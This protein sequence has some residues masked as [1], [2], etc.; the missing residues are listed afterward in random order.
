M[1][2]SRTLLAVDDNSLDR[3]IMSQTLSAAFPDARIRVVGEPSE[4]ETLCG[5]QRFDCVLL[6]QNLPQMDGLTLARRLRTSDPHMPIILV[7]SIGDEML[8]AEAMRGGVS[9]YLTK[10]R[11]TTEAARRVVDRAIQSAAQQRLIDQ[12]HE[13]LETFA[14]ALAHD[15]KQPIRQIMTFSQMITDD[16]SSV[17]KAGVQKHLD[18]LIHAAERLDKLVDVM[19][20]YTLLSQPPELSNVRLDAVVAAIRASLTPLLSELHAELEVKDERAVIRGNETLMIQVLQNLIVN[21][22]RYN[23]SRVPRVEVLVRREAETYVIEVR[24]NGVGIAAE[25]L[26]EIFKPLIRLHSHKE[27]PGSGLG[28]TL[29]RKAVM[30]QKGDIWCE[31]TPGRGS[32][33]SLRLAAGG[34]TAKRRRA[35]TPA[36]PE[37]ARRLS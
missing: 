16:L 30:A 12:Q 34:A 2:S 25:Y 29:A 13:E 5:A 26:S 33:F 9:D 36:D 11:L 8:A 4:A 20:Q 10:S 23:K 7:T 35:A 27:Y 6:D 37:K 19:V 28:L 14:Y 17:R 24:D 1:T 32:V 18:F 22:L 3:E 15:F 21:G 31:S